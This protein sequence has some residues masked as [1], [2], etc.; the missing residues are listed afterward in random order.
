MHAHMPCSTR[1][2]PSGVIPADY[3]PIRALLGRD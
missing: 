1:Y 2:E 3:L